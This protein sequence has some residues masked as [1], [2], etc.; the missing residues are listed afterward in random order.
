MRSIFIP[1]YS[2]DD[3]R[4]I[5]MKPNTASNGVMIKQISNDDAALPSGKNS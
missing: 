1:V 5:S 4:D 3:W 2:Y